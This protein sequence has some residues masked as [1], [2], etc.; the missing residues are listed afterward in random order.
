MAP[1]TREWELLESLVR[2][3]RLERTVP[4]ALELL[5][6]DPLASAGLFAGD[7]LR[8]LLETPG[9]FW[10]R[11]PALHRRFLAAVRAGAL[12]RRRLPPALRME[13]WSPL[14]IPA[15]RGRRN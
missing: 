6:G 5:E 8:A 3:E 15:A 4:R 2:H 12:A 13:F 10:A 14:E 11:H 1:H 7:L 9:G